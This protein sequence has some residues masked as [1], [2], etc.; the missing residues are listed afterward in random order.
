MTELAVQLNPFDDRAL[1]AVASAAAQTDSQ[2]AIAEVQAAMVVARANPR[3]QR[4]AM[5]RILNACQR[6]GL[7]EAAVYSYSRGGT[8]IS[9]PSIRLAEAMA[10]NWGNMQFGIRELDQANG[11]S[12]VQA[13]AWD[14][15]T[16]T[17][18]EVTFQVRHERHTKAGKKKLDDPRDIY[19]T[20]ANNGARR[21]RS[22]IL[23]VI[24][25]DVT[26]SAVRQ[27]EETMKAKADTSPAGLKKLEAALGEFGVTRAQIEARIQRRMDAITPAQVVA[28]RKVWA[29]L[30]DGMSEVGDWFD[31]SADAQ[32]A[33]SA[34][35]QD[36]VT[37]SLATSSPPMVEGQ[38]WIDSMNGEIRVCRAGQ[39]DAPTEVQEKELR[40]AMLRE[41]GDNAPKNPN[42]MTCELASAVM[43]ERRHAEQKGKAKG[44]AK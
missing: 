38:F 39:W 37:W 44:G 26:E 3:N 31:A 25:G 27:C 42:L 24:P 29:S 34:K 36:A 43:H 17:R 40:T 4:V 18:R 9:G 19:E 13:F 5:D 20:V 30:R 11:V 2:R 10:Q 8:D 6:P 33:A 16:N 32:P 21:L 41:L 14:V 1:P 23:A 28:L 7:A 35:A 22:C 15:E 12:T